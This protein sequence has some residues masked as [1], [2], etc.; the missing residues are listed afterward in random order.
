[1]LTRHSLVTYNTLLATPKELSRLHLASGLGYAIGLV[2]GASTIVVFTMW[3]WVRHFP[4]ECAETH[5]LKLHDQVFFL[6]GIMAAIVAVLAA[7][8][9]PSVTVQP[10]D[11]VLRAMADIDWIGAIA[12]SL[13]FVLF[14]AAFLLSGSKWAWNSIQV[15]SLWVAIL[16]LFVFSF[17]QHGYGFWIP[18]DR[19]L[20][21][22][23]LQNRIGL[24]SLFVVAAAAGSLS[25]MLYGIALF[26]AFVRGEEAKQIAI[27]LLPALGCFGV[28]SILARPTLQVVRRP[29]VLYLCGGICVS[30]GSGGLMWITAHTSPGI[31][32]GISC[33]LG[34][35]LGLMSALPMPVLEANLPSHLRNGVSVCLVT[36]THTFTTLPLALS[37]CIYLN[38][39]YHNLL[40]ASGGMQ[41]HSA[42]IQQAL[43]GLRSPLLNLEPS[44]IPISALKAGSA[45]IMDVFAIGIAAGVAM[46]AAA[47]IDGFR[48]WPLQIT[49]QEN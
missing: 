41:I 19:I 18:G 15:I 27:H 43:A 23:V 20:P 5:S 12:H 24:G 22:G 42:E 16:V 32:I 45:S 37:G 9:Y 8:S 33:L 11:K 31:V 13:S 47:F 14:D 46:M 4:A 21:L 38:R 6:G 36:V 35:S 7:L 26:C 49:D 48:P 44:E 25:V 2:L 3:R 10:E 17:L 40:E 30:A 1:M 28:T 29:A 39:G 34:S